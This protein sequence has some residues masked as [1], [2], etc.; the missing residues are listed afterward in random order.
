M[1]PAVAEIHLP[2]LVANYRALSALAAPARVLAVVKADAYGHGAAACA[3]ALQRAGAAAFGVAAIEEALE[4]RAAGV[5]AP[6]VLLEGV[7]EP[8][9]YPIVAKEGFWPV[10]H[11]EAQ[12]CWL[13]EHGRRGQPLPAA[14]WVKIDTGMHR[15]G[16]APQEV[17]RLFARLTALGT[18]PPALVW[19]T[20]LACADEPGNAHTEAQLQCFDAA[21]AAL[22]NAHS[23]TVS[24]ANSAALLA[25]PATRRGWVRPGLALYGANPLVAAAAPTRPFLTDTAP[26]DGSA[27]GNT[28]GRTGAPQSF[29]T[30]AQLRR[31]QPVMSLRSALLATRWIDA[32]ETVGYGATF[33]A[34]RRSRIGIIALGYADGYPREVPNGTP[35]WV[36]GWRVP[37]AGRV[38]MDMLAVDLTDAPENATGVG[39]PVELWGEHVAVEEVAAAAGTIPYTLLTAVHRV[40]RAIIAS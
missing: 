30:S 21:L 18:S 24:L 4:L 6:I 28:K 36:G 15:L 23:P 33:V 13:E 9:E 1:R 31:L 16:F 38:S 32:G 2:A 20:H 11:H 10:L 14:I 27:A 25:W 7:F 8:G 34:A 17:P 40:R 26:T 39:A 29:S 3:L 12:L 19:M 22:P 35:V 37:L 5:R